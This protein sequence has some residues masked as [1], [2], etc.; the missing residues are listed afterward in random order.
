MDDESRLFTK[1]KG[2]RKVNLA[3]TPKNRWII[4]LKSTALVVVDMQRGFL[5]KEAPLSI[6]G[7][8]ELV[9]RVNEL[10]TTCRRLSLPVIFLKANRR[11][12][13]SDSGLLLDI[14]TSN[15]VDNEMSTSQGRK[16]NELH[17]DLNVTQDDYI[18]PKVRYSALIPGSSSLEPLLRG[19]GRD[20]LI[21]CGVATD[22]CV[23]ATTSTAMMLGYK[24]F[25]VGDLT[26][27]YTKERQKIALEVYDMHYCKVMTFNKV[28]EELA[29][30]GGETRL[31]K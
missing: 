10:T 8:E 18:V 3:I 6:V 29:H 22:V 19:L 16:G 7:A 24:V 30:L 15:E 21:I 14:F 5:D 27:T 31:Q 1:P 25:L 12:D 28:M 11:A 2:E 20:S 17:P 26:A 23:G 13:L 4:S 9:P